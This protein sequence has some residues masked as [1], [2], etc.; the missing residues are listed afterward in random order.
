MSDNAQGSPSDSEGD[1]IIGSDYE[2][3]SLNITDRVHFMDGNLTI[4]EGG[5]LTVEN[6][7]ISFT[8]DTGVDGIPGTSDDRVYKLTVEDGGKL[9]MR[10][11]TLTTE[12]DQIND[13]PSLGMIV[14][15]GGHVE[16][17]DSVMRFPG[18][19]AV[20]DSTFIMRNSNI[21]GHSSD[22][23]EDY[24]DEDYFPGDKFSHSPVTL[25]MSSDVRL[26]DSEIR[27]VY[28][29]NSTVDSEELH[30]QT[31]SFAREDGNRSTVTYN[32]SRN[33]GALGAGNDTTGELEDLTKDDLEYFEVEDGQTLGIDEIDVAGMLFDDARVTLNV[34]YITDP[35]YAGSDDFQWGYENGPMS[36]SAP[37]IQDTTEEY[38]TSDNP[39][40]VESA[41][42]G[43]MSST[44]LSDLNITYTNN[45]GETA[46]INRV[47]VSVEAPIDT[48]RNLTTAGNTQFTAVDSYLGVDFS[49][50][51][52]DH[53]RLV[54]TDNSNAYLYGAHVDM[55]ENPDPLSDR[56][57]AYVSR[58][59]RMSASPLAKGPEDN[60]GEDITDLIDADDSFYNVD[61]GND[62]SIDKFNTSDIDDNLIG[63]HLSVTYKTEA[64]YSGTDY[65]KYGIEG[66]PLRNTSIGID[67]AE[68][69]TTE[70]FDLYSN[71]I[72]TIQKIKDLNIT[73][74]NTDDD[75]TVSFDEISIE[76]DLR[77]TMYLY[78]WASID[79]ND[80]Q[81][82][83]V[84]GAVINA[85]L[86]S[87]DIPAY[88]QTPDGIQ[89]TPPQEVLDYLGR[90]A[91]NYKM[92]DSSG[93]ARIPLLTEY[94]DAGTYPN[95]EVIGSYDLDMTYVNESESSFHASAS[96]EF[97]P[98]PSLS[99]G[100][101]TSLVNVT[102]SELVLDKP[103]LVVSSIEL[104]A[105]PVY[106]DETVMIYATIENLGITSATDFVVQLTDLYEGSST[107]VENLTVD[108][109][110]GGS[111]M[112]F[113]V[114]WGPT[115]DGNHT[116]TAFADSNETVIEDDEGNNE[117][118][119]QV[120]V[121]P[122]I[123]DLS[124]SS[125]DINFSEDPA[126]TGQEVEIEAK[127]R[128]A[129]GRDDA[130]NVTVSFF[131]AT[132]DDEHLIGETEVNVPRGGSNSATITWEPSQIGEYPIHV[133]V[134]RQRDI[135]EYDYTNNTAHKNITVDL[136]TDESDWAVEGDTTESI[137]GGSPEIKNNVVVRDN[138]TLI[139]NSTDLTVYQERDNQFQILVEDNATLILLNSS[140]SSN[141][142]ALSLYM[143]DN[144]QVIIDPSLIGSGI[145]IHLN[146]ESEL[147]ILD[148]TI[149]GDIVAP[150]SSNGVLIAENTTF[151]KTWS[152]FGGNAEANL[153]SVSAP[154]LVAREDAVIRHYR[155][156]TVEVK[157]GNGYPL[158][159]AQVSMEY[160]NLT[161]T[162]YDEK[163]SNSSGEVLFRS[164]CD[165]IT[166][167]EKD[168]FGNYLLNAT[169]WFD[170]ESY[171][172]EN[173]SVS[174]TPY[175]PPVKKDDRRAEVTIESALPDLD[176]PFFVS[177]DTPARNQEVNLSANVSNVGVVPAN[178]VVVRFKDNESVI[179]DVTVE[180][181]NPGETVIVNSTWIA[182]YPLGWHNLSVIVDP[183]DAITEMNT[184]NNHN[185]TM[186][187][188]QGV[189]YLALSQSDVE[190]DPPSP[191]VNTSTAVTV[192]VRNTGDVEA[193]NVNLSLYVTPEGGTETLVDNSTISSIAVDGSGVT[194]LHWVPSQTGPH[195]L[196]LK[197][198]DESSTPELADDD[199]ELNLSVT[200]KDYADLEP[201]QLS[202][203]PSGEVEVGNN[204]TMNAQVNNLGETTARNVLVRYW[205]GGIS[206]GEVI[207][208]VTV[209]V[210]EPGDTR[211][212]SGSWLANTSDY[213]KS[214]SRTISVEVNPDR[215][216]NETDYTNDQ[217][218]DTISVMD[219]RPDFLIMG[220]VNVTS[221]DQPVT[222]A[223]VG[224]KLNITAD[225]RN[226]GLEAALGVTISFQAID[227]DSFSTWIGEVTEDFGPGETVTANMNWTVNAT[228]GANDIVVTVNPQREIQERNYDNDN[229]S[230]PLS[231]DP[232]N[233]D[234]S[235]D[236]GGV[237]QYESDT[238]VFVRGTVE[239]NINDEPLSDV[240]VSVML[241]DLSG[242]PIGDVQTATT[243]SNGHFET[244]IY[245]P[246]GIEG[247]YLIEVQVD[248]GESTHTKSADISVEPIFEETAIPWWAWLIVIAV[249]AGVV[250]GFSYYLYRYGLGKMVECG[251]C[252]ALI[253]E[254]SKKCP[255]CGVGFETG[256][257]KCSECGAWIPAS[258][259]VC[260]ECGAKFV[261]EAIGEEEDEY[262]RSMREQYEAMLDDQRERAK[263]DLGDKYSEA[264]FKD[265]WKTQPNYV[266]FEDWLSEEEE[267][268]KSSAFPCPVCGTLNPKGSKVCH[269]CGTVFEEQGEREE[270][271][272]KPK[273]K[274]LRRI[275]RRP[276]GKAREGTESAEGTS[277]E[278]A[279]DTSAE[280]ETSKEGT[281][282]TTEESFEE[283]EEK[284]E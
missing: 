23:I 231:I 236:L 2:T 176:P 56:D 241:T 55:E 143:F 54:T 255:K 175:S 154:A 155:W 124:V 120:D 177:N 188:V 132:V 212:A 108:L 5:V 266:S 148:S 199:D 217:L 153:T 110:E 275:V 49:K 83:P 74:S 156:L 75:S 238:Q 11:S 260:P 61:S 261:G 72:D 224:E 247:D 15:N 208:E 192:T 166:S 44:D 13:Y 232:P 272:E 218:T 221:E 31:Y 145:T 210:I 82:L 168:F 91:T 267:R 20:D 136:D 165:R 206:T 1:L 174:W 114:E 131:S 227:N 111:S 128:N 62:L 141:N 28:E 87:D 137:V 237:Y 240:Q 189:V 198:V 216:I 256:T 100:N 105:D 121:L 185:N 17:N 134:N 50:T 150:S 215:D 179:E 103:D 234:I 183:E 242:N 195:D 273:R 16:M 99:E 235:I 171:E 71:D 271:E 7:G 191:T 182:D 265:W 39:D 283:D 45:G 151:T 21:T 90:N 98:Y 119:I 35:G 58:E 67:N 123:P 219:Y 47:W 53:N 163:T 245:I 38:N 94:V 203:S 32:L 202:F 88:Y 162:K 181:I 243:N 284:K 79:L 279:E 97:Y 214:E 109:L 268:R 258:A 24:C 282:E 184:S 122:Q 135:Q 86:Q 225:V 80:N 147:T 93:K 126:P 186:V 30:N 233:P 251:E 200:V 29:G 262:I 172:S 209:S 64:G 70:S 84:E 197:A 65:V 149:E 249:V 127:V 112:D 106:D 12:L 102:M 167:S 264:K 257:A 281:E 270:A 101:Q 95:S 6:G 161:G 277:P 10:N 142:H 59:S 60:T 133:E 178:D 117:R 274:P 207:D 222:N 204:L 125:D 211:T 194:T 66:E 253:P 92:T 89:S 160:N 18:H 158:P 113:V 104:G 41:V 37:T 187:D 263:E 248:A 169:F 228:V 25:F 116:L 229:A 201:S 170:G 77:P 3:S 152:S 76:L 269:K 252:G 173:T 34:K 180:E 4:R 239:N 19:L 140:I 63:A 230:I 51:Q 196:R 26:Y 48:Y 57:P 223:S 85:T 164:L 42:L 244:S 250:V 129:E 280:G 52:D 144:A 159:D 278:T 8:Q 22:D 213:Q 259:T 139:L 193:S 220:D 78:R 14:Q 43:N 69:S 190:V 9:I 27:K 254:N 81:S 107:V 246:P 157:D 36:A 96:P 276:V 33:P 73:F 146:H 205:L 130:K 226:D 40:E 138:A 46:Y 68:A 118:S 115:P